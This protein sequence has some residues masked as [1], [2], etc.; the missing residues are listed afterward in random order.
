MWWLPCRHMPFIDSLVHARRRAKFVYSQ[1]LFNKSRE[2]E[3][4]S[5][6]YKGRVTCLES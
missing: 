5:E 6:A 2:V 3:E 4:E 1:S